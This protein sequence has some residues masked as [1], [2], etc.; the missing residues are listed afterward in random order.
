M[1]A[2]RFRAALVAAV[3]LGT[4]V[5][6]GSG[7]GDQVPHD[8][9]GDDAI[10]VGSFDFPESQLLAE[11]YSQALERG[12][13]RVER[14]FALGPRELVAPALEG[15]MLELVPEY[16]GT[17]MQYYSLGEDEPVSDVGAMHDALAAVL[18]PVGIDALEPA[19]AQD[20]NVFAVTT[21]TAGRLR[22]RR[23]SD[24]APH[25]GSMTIGGPP[26]CEIRTLC[27]VGLHSV[28]GLTFE[29][30]VPLGAGGALAE[31]ALRENQVDVALLFSTAA[32]LVDQGL[33]VLNDD[34]GL[35]PAENITPLVRS[36]VVDRWGPEVV[37]R[38]NAASRHLTTEDLQAM[39]QRL[40]NGESIAAVA[41]SFLDQQGLG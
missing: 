36:E 20:A 2:H 39:N 37:D 41:T 13:Y 26:E 29:D 24:L 4:V 18:A 6:C 1:A 23:I 40:A 9:L 30:F 11:I 32:G 28:Y 5:G 8:A 35:Q 3:V 16:A 34:R 17:A 7:A 33:V 22:L 25:A 15:G 19:P 10:T 31:Q 21:R 38:V 14:A 27:L 12:G